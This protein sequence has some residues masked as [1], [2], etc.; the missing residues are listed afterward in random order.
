MT[1][2]T[3]FL[4]LLSPSIF[5]YVQPFLSSWRSKEQKRFARLRSLQRFASGLV[6]KLCHKYSRAFYIFVTLKK[7]LLLIVSIINANRIYL[8]LQWNWCF[9][10]RNKLYIFCRNIQFIFP[11]EWGDEQSFHWHLRNLQRKSSIHG[12][13][14]YL[15]M[16]EISLRGN[17]VYL[18][19]YVELYHPINSSRLFCTI[20]RFSSKFVRWLKQIECLD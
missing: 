2:C 10:Y 15:C 16:G 4:I 5:R 11:T 18:Y 1:F 14:F 9:F 20:M 19:V 12:R 8:K 7:C 6:H 13:L 3:H 17:P